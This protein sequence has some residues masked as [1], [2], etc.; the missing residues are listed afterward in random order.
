MPVEVQIQTG[1][2]APLDYILRPF[3]DFIERGMR[4][5][6]I[7]L[8][9]ITPRQDKLKGNRMNTLR[10]KLLFSIVA[11][12]SVVAQVASANEKGNP[13]YYGSLHAINGFGVYRIEQPNPI[14]NLADRD[15]YFRLW[16]IAIT[17]ASAA[18]TQLEGILECQMKGHVESEF[19]GQLNIVE[20]LRGEENVAKTLITQGYAVEICAETGGRLGT[21]Q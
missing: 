21:C 17:N 18:S 3:L 8:S 12:S 11:Y 5:W 2:H 14:Y 15:N 13:I 16:G 19:T 6:N 9:L 4:E 20:C 1:S 7:H 10:K